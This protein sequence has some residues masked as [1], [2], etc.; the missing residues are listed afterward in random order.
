MYDPLRCKP[1]SAEVS[2]IITQA[3]FITYGAIVATR[4]HTSLPKM[5]MGATDTESF[6]ETE[7][8][9]GVKVER[10]TLRL[11]ATVCES[12]TKTDL[13]EASL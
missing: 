4:R 10:A 3:A 11:T 6:L 1:F 5:Q 13:K 2:R 9:G 7:Q 12:N 8:F